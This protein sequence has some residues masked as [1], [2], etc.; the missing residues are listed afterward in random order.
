MTRLAFAFA[1]LLFVVSCATAPAPTAP[2]SG[3]AAEDP[4]MA[5]DPTAAAAPTIGASEDE[6]LNGLIAEEWEWT[7]R[8]FPTFATSLGDSRYDDRLTDMSPEAIE[9]RKKHTRET[10]ERLRQVDRERLSP[11]ARINYDLLIRETEED[12]EGQQF[13]SE[14]LQINQRGGVHTDMAELAEWV[15]KSGVKNFEDYLTRLRQTPQQVEHSIA[16]LRAGMEKGV[17]PPRVTLR[18]VANLIG[19]Q[20]VADPRSS[21]IFTTAFGEMPATIP[22]E[23]QERLRAEAAKVLRDDVI[24]AYR[25][26]QR[27]FADEYYP[28]TRQEVGL[29]SLPN[30]Q[31]WYAH[32]AKTMTTTSMTPEEIHQ[33]GLSEVKRIRAEM[34]T[35]KQQTGFKGPLAD[36]FKFLRT[37]RRFYFKEKEALLNEYRNIAKR[38]DPELPRIFGK[39]PRLPYGVQPVPAYSEKTNTTAYY[40][41]GSL[42]AGRAGVFYANTYNLAARP[43]W[44]MEAL[45]LHE[46]VPGHHLQIALAEELT[47]LPNF[48]RFGGYTAFVE[49]WGLYAESLGSE[50]GMYKDPYSRFGQLTYEMWR[51]VRLVVDTGM[52]AK[53]WSRQQAIDFFKENA[54]KTEHDIVVE[55]DRYLVNPGQALAYKIGELKLKELRRYATEQLGERFDIRRFHDEVL[56]AGALP[57]SVLEIR[58][59][60]WVEKE[61]QGSS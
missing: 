1:L 56:G 35:V 55:I 44:E 28:R 54:G 43:K 9:R 32:R 51:A 18:E 38:I 12:I 41:Q 53:G 30:G 46:A 60:E 2:Q 58:V 26:L 8:E 22:A 20:L 11:T 23:E 45:T 3:S 6:A 52:H 59:K 4:P 40:N 21:P 10:L 36:F 39:L 14:Y 42:K 33:L 19:N 57:L 17:T 61:K 34:E 31:A 13:P 49:G 29:S 7:M 27:F 24:P 47:D 50:L 5:A 16:L 15:P 37:D 25:K 48:R